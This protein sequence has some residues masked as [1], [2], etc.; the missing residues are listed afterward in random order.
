MVTSVYELRWPE[1]LTLT[2]LAYCIESYCIYVLTIL[3][4]SNPTLATL[5]ILATRRLVEVV[6]RSAAQHGAVQQ[7]TQATL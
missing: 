2:I 5:T 1:T 3:C 7:A 4:A 6:I